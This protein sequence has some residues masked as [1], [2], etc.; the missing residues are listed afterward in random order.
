MVIRKLYP[1]WKVY[2][3]NIGNYDQIKFWASA[4]YVC[5]TT[6][7][8]VLM[9]IFRPNFLFIQKYLFLFFSAAKQ[10]NKLPMG[11]S[12]SRQQKGRKVKNNG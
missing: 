4:Q 7:N 3:S 10:P 1:S 6:Q 11:S 5:M 8:D 2:M 12:E 9:L